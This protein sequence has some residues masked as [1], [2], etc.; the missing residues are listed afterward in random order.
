MCS[1]Y[2]APSPEK[3]AQRFGMAMPKIATPEL[4]RDRVGVYSRRPPEL[5]SGD[6]AVP[7]L[8]AHSGRWGLVPRATKA[9]QLEKQMALSTFNARD[10]RVRK[11]WTFGAAWRGAQRCIVPAEAIYEPDWR[12]GKA[13]RT[14]FTDAGGRLLN[15]AGL[16]SNWQDADGVWS[17][18]FTMLT[19]SAKDHPLFKHYHRPEKE[20]RMVCLLFEHQCDAWLDAPV[21]DAMVF[22]TSAQQYPADL[23]VATPAPRPAQPKAA[24]KKVRKPEEPSSQG[25]LL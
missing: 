7:R 2:E 14:R 6:E 1:E 12:S 23:L 22:L 24:A 9:H 3:F 20:K 17:G 18:S 19:T 21:D 5:E 4:F 8:E 13:V 16:W 11:A 15:I 25:L 10:D